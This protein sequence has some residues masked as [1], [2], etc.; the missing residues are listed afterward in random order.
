MLP[1]AAAL[2]S[3]KFDG[4]SA[5]DLYMWTRD[6]SAYL[7]AANIASARN[8]ALNGY[9]AG[10][11]Y[12]G[13]G[14]S[15]QFQGGWYL[16]SALGMYTYVPYA[17]MMSSPF[18]YRFFSPARIYSYYSPT[19]YYWYGSGGS[20]AGPADGEPLSGLLSPSGAIPGITS[21]Q[22]TLASPLRGSS[23]TLAT[24]GGRTASTSSLADSAT[25]TRAALEAQTRDL[26]GACDGMNMGMGTYD[27][28]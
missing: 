27:G 17:G 12:P 23:A 3:E 19:P 26:N 21:S 13:L 25:S 22:P 5:D 6:R 7:S 9:V 4:N 16:N 20:P 15:P 18:G 2:L 28:H 11:S 8:L 1:F 24:S 14:F 10:S